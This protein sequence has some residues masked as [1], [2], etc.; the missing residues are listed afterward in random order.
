MTIG[1]TQIDLIFVRYCKVIVI[2]STMEIQSANGGRL[3]V[4][5]VLLVMPHYLQ[6]GT[7]LF[8]FF[9]QVQRQCDAGQINPEIALQP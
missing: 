4:S 3:S 6:P 7:Q 2:F 5:P 9:D 1:K 8:E